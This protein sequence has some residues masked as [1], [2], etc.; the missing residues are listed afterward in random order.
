[1]KRRVEVKLNELKP[2]PY[3][4][5]IQRGELEEAAVNRIMESAE[6]TSFW[7]QWVA[8]EI[9]SGYELAFGHNRLE[10]A[11]RVLGKD[12]KVSVQIEPYTDEQMYIALADENAKGEQSLAARVDTVMKARQLL[13]ANPEWCRVEVLSEARTAHSKFARKD[14]QHEHGSIDCIVAWLGKENW[15]RTTV[16]ECLQMGEAAD[17]ELL[18][19][20]SIRKPTAG[21]IG[22]RAVLAL[23]ELKDKN[24]QRAAVEAIQQETVAIPFNLIEEA[25]EEVKRLP[26]ERQLEGIKRTIKTKAE[27]AKLRKQNHAKRQ[28]AKGQPKPKKKLPDLVQLFKGVKFNYGLQVIYAESVLDDAKKFLNIPEVVRELA[29][30][31]TQI[32]EHLASVERLLPKRKTEPVRTA[33]QVLEQL[34]VASGSLRQ[35]KAN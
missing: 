5:F 22:E 8:R 9:D 6:R 3:K 26:E 18:N 17:R 13:R 30:Y 4:K 12:A 33:S 2:N 16:G 14:N 10:A 25:V 29:E 21:E 20:A 32:A 28:A 19:A 7:E 35:L 24:V 15:A 34:G 31:R 27:M 1:M 23:S 11:R